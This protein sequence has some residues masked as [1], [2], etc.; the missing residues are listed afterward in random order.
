M[1]Y[2]KR[3]LALLTVLNS[4]DHIVRPIEPCLKIRSEGV[5]TETCEKSR[6][7]MLC[8]NQAT[9]WSVIGRPIA[10]LSLRVWIGHCTHKQHVAV[11]YTFRG[12]I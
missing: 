10:S 6:L 9:A 3:F 5:F 12:D 8:I 11:A 1:K 7:R 2:E 4:L